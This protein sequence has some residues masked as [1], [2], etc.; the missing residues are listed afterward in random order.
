MRY[1]AEI[2]IRDGKNPS[3][4]VP[5]K[6]AHLPGFYLVCFDCDRDD[7]EILIDAS[8][9]AFY[10]WAAISCA[11][12]MPALAAEFLHNGE[13]DIES[14]EM[15]DITVNIPER[16]GHE[17]LYDFEQSKMPDNVERRGEPE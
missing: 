5:E 1:R 10:R 11:E 15:F 2:N 4:P 12:R 16:S 14:L 7:E 9:C 13:P 17:L 6:F 3:L 8:L